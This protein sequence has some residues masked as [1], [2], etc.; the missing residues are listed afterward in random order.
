MAAE[1]ETPVTTIDH[2]AENIG[3][4]GGKRAQFSALMSTLYNL[5]RYAFKETGRNPFQYCIGCT[6]VFLV[7]F[8]V[9]LVMTT[10]SVT[11]LVFLTIAEGTQ[12]E[13]DLRVANL[14]GTGY[15][16]LNYTMAAQQLAENPTSSSVSLSSSSAQSRFLFHSPRYADEYALVY[17]PLSCAGYDPNN[18]TLNSFS[19]YGPAA[20]PDKSLENTPDE[21]MK[22]Q[23][24]LNC[25]NRPWRCMAEVCTN[26][27]DASMWWIDIQRERDLGM[28]RKWDLPPLGP[29]EVY[30]N[31][32]LADVLGVG[33]GDIIYTTLSFYTIPSTYRI[34][35]TESF[36]ANNAALYGG[37][38]PNKTAPR[39][40][41]DNFEVNVPLRVKTVFPM[42]YSTKFPRWLR[43]QY[44]MVLEYAHILE[45]MGPYVHPVFPPTF[46]ARMKASSGFNGRLYE[47][48]QQI[49]FACDSPRYSC[50]MAPDYPTIAGALV[51]WAS[52]IVFRL[53]VN[54]VMGSMDL[55]GGYRTV[56]VFARFLGLI[57]SVIIVLLCAL[58]VFLVYHLLMGS[59]ETRMFELGVL[60]MV[61]MTRSG[62]ITI[63]LIQ[64]MTYAIPAWVVGLILAQVAF[65]F[66][67]G[68]LESVASVPISP[69][70][71]SDAILVSTVLGVVVPIISAILPIRRALS[72]NI[73]DSLDKRTSSG[74]G[75][76]GP[77]RYSGDIY[78]G[79][80]ADGC[81]FFD[82]L[83]LASGVGG[84]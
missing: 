16:R 4:T 20:S 19:Y 30:I 34:I 76:G 24:R 1:I 55:L 17:N 61:G 7:V 47:E 10:L 62:V 44:A 31:Q 63:L 41:F 81:G 21:V 23:L 32:R 37:T 69:Y 3:K 53:G 43:S 66:G 28:G 74:L 22:R 51:K 11:P 71:R 84:E 42:G 80:P 52:A 27:V 59:V 68:I 46:A 65:A 57:S 29:N 25:R 78:L 73:R 72:N 9:A 14:W 18:Y 77:G 70:L 54:T 56:A 15:S 67:K 60:R 12:G 50:Y 39:G 35:R 58:S 2:D 64:A 13:A 75:R 26:Y 40:F 6:S 38:Q 83:F 82:L 8:A 48:A 79:T 33:E 5:F 49:V 45:S 36:I